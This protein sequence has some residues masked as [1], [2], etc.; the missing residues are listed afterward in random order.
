MNGLQRKT[1][2]MG[3]LVAFVGL[4]VTGAAAQT[5]VD[6]TTA[7]GLDAYQ[8]QNPDVAVAWGDYDGNGDVDLYLGAYDFTQGSLYWN[9]GSGFAQ[10]DPGPTFP[11]L[12]V[13]YNNDGRPDIAYAR[14]DGQLYRGQLNGWFALTPV[15]DT[16]DFNNETA[17]FGDFNGDGRLDSYR[18]GWNDEI[19][20]NVGAPDALYINDRH[21]HMVKTL[22][23]TGVA[24]WRPSRSAT[25]CDFDQDGD[26]DIYVCNYYLQNN[27]LWVN[28]GRGGLR[29]RAVEYGVA[30]D[31]LPFDPNFPG[32][33]SIGATWGDLD[34][35]GWF[36]LIVANLSHGAP[37][38]DRPVFYRNLGPAGGFRFEDVSDLVALPFTE[39]YASPALADFDNDGDLDL[40]MTAVSGAGYP[41]QESRLMRNDGNWTFT[42]VST[43]YGLNLATAETN[44]GAAWADYDNDGDLDLY[45]DRRLFQNPIANGHHWLMVNVIG[46]GDHVARQ[47]IG[48]QVRIAVGGD[49]LTRQVETSVGWGN[50]SDPRLHFGLGSAAGPVD[51]EIIW[52][53]GHRQMVAGVGVDQVI[54]VTY[55]VAYSGV[56]DAV[57]FRSNA[58]NGR[59]NWLVHQTRPDPTYFD[60][61]DGLALPGMMFHD[62]VLMFGNANSIPL[63]GDVDGNGFDDLVFV[64]AVTP[65]QYTWAA[66]HTGDDGSGNGVLTGAG[67]SS[68]AAWGGPPGTV[69]L[70]DINGD[71]ADDCLVVLPGTANI[72]VWQALHGG[73]AGIYGGGTST[74]VEWGVFGD[75]LFVGDFDG[76]GIDDIGAYQSNGDIGIKRGTA[77]GLSAGSGFMVGNFASAD[78]HT[79]LVGDFDADGQD[80]VAFW[81]V[82]PNSM[83]KWEVVYADATG[84]IDGANA[85]APVVFGMSDDTPY[86]AD[87]NGDG[88]ADIVFLR[89]DLA[90]NFAWYQVGFTD[91]SGL[92]Y[93]LGEPGDDYG[94]FGFAGSST[95]LFG[96]L[97]SSNQRADVVEY[98][99]TAGEWEVTLNQATPGYLDG[100]LD[101]YLPHGTAASVPLVGDVNGDGVDDLVTASP[102]GQRIPRYRWD[103]VHSVLDPNNGV[104]ILSAA[105]RSAVTRLGRMDR[106]IG[107][108]LADVNNDGC[109]DIITVNDAYGWAAAFSVPG[110]G[111][112][113]DVLFS[114]TW[115]N[116]AEVPLVGDFNGDGWADICAHNAAFGKWFVALSGPAGFGNRGLITDGTFGGGYPYV[117]DVNGDGRDDAILTF[118]NGDGQRRWRV[119][120]AD[121]NG[122][123]DEANEGTSILFGEMT[124]VPRV[125]DVNGD[126]RADLGV[127]YDDGID[128]LVW[129]FTFTDASGQ[130]GGG[131]DQQVDESQVFGVSPTGNIGGVSDIPLAMNLQRVRKFVL[132]DQNDDSVV[133]GDDLPL[134]GVCVTGPDVPAAG[135]EL[136]DL[137]LDDDVDMSDVSRFQRQAGRSSAW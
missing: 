118:D 31:A 72:A 114:S 13:D 65:A 61:P 41:G 66:A 76:D 50:Q 27:Y 94:Q 105:E 51:L 87:V 15:F 24:D 75:K 82:D 107:R 21:R 29:D 121:P 136:N 74:L 33:N 8:P 117:G 132:G 56:T 43:T 130:P 64:D 101:D 80:D 137:D 9:G 86:V 92:P 85:A 17:T 46:D 122:L 124:D 106:I 90:N 67:G 12:F 112:S 62:Q 113:R 93:A 2:R 52:P 133:D 119:A 69:F 19:G 16:H 30:A 97:D 35:D 89:A 22:M 79:P 45:T 116:P 3:T 26:L 99:Q 102:N 5:F 88:R 96:Q 115:G 23:Q 37:E 34:N 83:L 126:G 55:D 20:G 77:S 28:D 25:V 81:S 4:L 10:L 128:S 68:I 58:R 98:R 18:P 135:C 48:A 108:F 100:T 32:G 44:F 40:F 84:E 11:G 104:G 109:D 57:V 39:S 125:M 59:A 110:F 134:Y 36:D 54:D 6:V 120:Y 1:A 131:A 49:V 111:L 7:M 103:A 42:D 14:A 123:I 71:D 53:N 63:V 70:A 38:S 60:D 91:A 95:S 73:P 78:T 127:V 129:E 47:P